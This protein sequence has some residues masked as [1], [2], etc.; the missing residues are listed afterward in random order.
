MRN[1]QKIP[2]NYQGEITLSEVLTHIE[3]FQ[4]FSIGWVRDSGSKRGQ[5]K[6]VERARKGTK[7]SD[8][9]FSNIPKARTEKKW[10]FKKY[11]MIPIQD[12]NKNILLTP[13]W[14]H[15]IEF[16]G[17]KVRHYGT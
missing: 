12:I 8:S 9:S 17:K 1:E 15:I 3:T 13:K 6:R 5:I 4:E 2:L 11:D 7:K 14:T 16:N 10:Q